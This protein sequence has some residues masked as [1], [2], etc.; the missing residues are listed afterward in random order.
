M[1]EPKNEPKALSLQQAHARE[2]LP[3]QPLSTDEAA[4]TLQRLEVAV[5]YNLDYPYRYAQDYYWLEVLASDELEA[6]RTA[7]EWVRNADEERF[8]ATD[9]VRRATTHYRILGSGADG[10]PLEVLWNV[11]IDEGLAPG[12]M[13]RNPITALRIGFIAMP[14]D[15][16]RWLPADAAGDFRL[17]VKKPVKGADPVCLAPLVRNLSALRRSPRT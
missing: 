8:E 7:Q 10:K 5:A 12:T 4:E 15:E 6:R 2:Q 1:S 13:I 16:R 17:I 9:F 14:E 11:P 3:G